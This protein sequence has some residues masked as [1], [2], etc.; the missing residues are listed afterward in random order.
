MSEQTLKY[1]GFKGSVEYSADDEMLVGKVLDVESLIM[2]GGTSVDEIHTAFHEAVDD[3]VA[4]C[5][6]NSV[7]PEKA[8]PGTFNVRIGG[9]LHRTAA[10]VARRRGQKLNELVK[11]AIAVEVVREDRHP[12]VGSVVTIVHRIAHAVEQWGTSEQL[13]PPS[14]FGADDE[15]FGPPQ[16]TA[17]THAVRVRPH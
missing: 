6:R 8:Y 14:E 4:T 9:D 11:R 15:D 12:A 10:M 17:P 7:A 1:K 13:S 2:Y 5:E 3:Y 16:F